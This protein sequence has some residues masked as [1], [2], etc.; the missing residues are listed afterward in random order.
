M[1]EGFL[2]SVAHIQYSVVT[3]VDLQTESGEPGEVAQTMPSVTPTQGVSAPAGLVAMA[4]PAK[5]H[6]SHDQV[7]AQ[8]QERRPVSPSPHARFGHIL[9]SGVHAALLV[10]PLHSASV[11]TAPEPPTA[12]A[13]PV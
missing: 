13:P 5:L 6:D 3:T 10:M 1:A 2:G 4:E 12:P 7:V 9:A 11:L 8:L